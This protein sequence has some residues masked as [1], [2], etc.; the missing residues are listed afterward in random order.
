VIITGARLGPRPVPSAGLIEGEGAPFEP[1]RLALVEP[2]GTRSV[3]GEP[4]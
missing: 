1:V 4:T 3:A 2:D